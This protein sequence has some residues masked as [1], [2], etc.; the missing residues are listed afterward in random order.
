MAKMTEQDVD[1]FLKDNSELM[2]DLTKLEE[3]E[4]QKL[5]KE[6]F[7]STDIYR[8]SARV[9]NYVDVEASLTPVGTILCNEF[10]HFIKAI[11]DFSETLTQDKKEELKALLRKNEEIPSKI[12]SLAKNLK[13]NR[14]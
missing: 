12:I 5:E 4:N 11:Y 7:E 3:D 6:R 10:T 14:K 2:D 1:K 13:V 9:K 8:V